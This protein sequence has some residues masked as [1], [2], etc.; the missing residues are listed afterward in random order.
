[1]DKRKIIVK[2]QGIDYT[3]VSQESDEYMQKVGLLVD[4]KM[5]EITD[6]APHLSTALAAVLTAINLADDYCK[7]EKT[8]DGLRFQVTE[9]DNQVKIN[10]QQLEEYKTELDNLTK[11]VNRLQIELAKKEAQLG[12]ISQNAN[13]NNSILP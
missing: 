5:K 9:Y 2:I 11:E 13:Y 8:L 3:I 10:K 12:T 6:M 7:S 1:M 4:K